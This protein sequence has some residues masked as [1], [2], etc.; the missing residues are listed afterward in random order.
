[1]I[2]NNEEIRENIVNNFSNKHI[3]IEEKEEKIELSVDSEKNESLKNKIEINLDIDYDVSKEFQDSL[4]P[5]KIN[6]TD[7]Q[8]TSNNETSKV[9]KPQYL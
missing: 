9:N 6:F 4:I 2:N 5:D 8:S 7:Y 3:K 1:M